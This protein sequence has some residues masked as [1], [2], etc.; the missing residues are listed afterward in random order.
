[1]EG[2]PISARAVTD[3]SGLE[4][5]RTQEQIAHFVKARL[6]VPDH[7]PHLRRKDYRPIQLSYWTAAA[8]LLVELQATEDLP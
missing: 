7:D 4:Y 8:R 6:L 2:K 5:N 1:M 3:E